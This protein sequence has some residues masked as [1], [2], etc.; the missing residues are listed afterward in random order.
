MSLYKHIKVDEA[1]KEHAPMMTKLRETCKDDIALDP[2][3][4]NDDLYLVRVCLS[5]RGDEKRAVESLKQG[6]AWRTKHKDLLAKLATGEKHP[7]EIA[8]SKYFPLGCHYLEDG[9]IQRAK[10]GSPLFFLRA[11]IGRMDRAMEDLD[12]QTLKDCMIFSKEIMHRICDEETRKRGYIVKLVTIQ[13]FKKGS[14]FDVDRKFMGYLGEA[15]KEMELI[16]CQLMGAMI[17]INPL[18]VMSTLMSIAKLI[19]PATVLEKF[20]ICKA[21]STRTGDIKTCPIAKFVFD[22]D[23]LPSYCG[24]KCDC[25]KKSGGEKKGCIANVVNDAHEKIEVPAKKK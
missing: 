2:Q 5:A 6:I 9:S 16:Y 25:G 4:F 13:D 1:I 24:G 21:A 11:G 14:V 20:K 23:Q 22:L 17:V 8:L 3:Q 18:S 19:L 10:D 15:S 7:A 12:A